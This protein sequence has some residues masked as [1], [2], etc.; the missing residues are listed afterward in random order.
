MAR[1]SL[2]LFALLASAAASV[3]DPAHSHNGRRAHNKMIRVR[4]TDD[5]NVSQA[6]PPSVINPTEPAPV[7]T[8]AIVG[9]PTEVEKRDASLRF[10]Y[11]ETGQ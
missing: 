7:A 1:F 10:T 4:S 6:P 2:V 8:P 9:E 3:T 5:P 11:Y